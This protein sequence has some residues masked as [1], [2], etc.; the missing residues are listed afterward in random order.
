MRWTLTNDELLDQIKSHSN[1]SF[2]DYKNRVSV[3]LPNF[4]E[5]VLEHWLYRH[6]EHIREDYLNLGLDKMLFTKEYWEP[7]AIVRDIN[8]AAGS[9]MDTMGH[10]LY[11]I[12]YW[13]SDY[14]L[15]N[16]T[17][18]N[19]IIVLK[20]ETLNNFGKPYHRLEG[21]KRLDYFREMYRKEKD[22]LQKTHE[23]WVATLGK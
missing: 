18:P 13:L 3:L 8:S 2:E 9:S 16:R 17:W 7:D 20:N 10:H 22:T 5:N 21:H 15:T 6:S 4:P 19:P 14:M 23:I 11:K 12:K 1:E